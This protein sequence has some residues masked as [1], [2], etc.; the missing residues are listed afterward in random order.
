MGLKN[1]LVSTPIQKLLHSGQI[2]GRLIYGIRA[3][4]FL[5]GENISEKL[6]MKLTLNENIK[7]NKKSN[8][9]FIK[10]NK[11]LYFLRRPGRPKRT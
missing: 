1:K 10:Y 9:I 4:K 2:N 7:Y 5:T 3:T 6:H 11:R 8:N